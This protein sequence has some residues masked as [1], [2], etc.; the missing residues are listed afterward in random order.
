MS[1]DG[2]S[3]AGS[4]PTQSASQAAHVQL[5]SRYGVDVTGYTAKEIKALDEGFDKMFMEPMFKA[6]RKLTEKLK[7]LNKENS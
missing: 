5:K 4:A 7:K 6:M 2:T 3:A 1:V